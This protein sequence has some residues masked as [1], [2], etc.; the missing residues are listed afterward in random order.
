MVSRRNFEGYETF[1]AVFDVDFGR[2]ASRLFEVLQGPVGWFGWW[3]WEFQCTSTL[4]YAT[5]M[6]LGT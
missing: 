1:V 3:T 6:E 5:W 4:F 2:K